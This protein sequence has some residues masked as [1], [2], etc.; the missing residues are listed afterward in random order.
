MAPLPT[1][2]TDSLFVDYHISGEDH[3]IQCRFASPAGVND[4]MDVVDGVLTAI[5]SDLTTVTIVGARQRLS[6]TTVTFPITWT[7]APSYGS[8]SGSHFQTASYM[9]FVGRSLDGR[10]VRFTIF[11]H[12]ALADTTGSDYRFDASAH[13]SVAAALVVLRGTVGTPCSISGQDATWKDYANIGV[14]A[15]WRNKIR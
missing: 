12:A 4:A 2:N 7:G 11:G 3:V 10:R 1:N 15:H 13:A 6:G 9:D 8:G 14:N 5:A